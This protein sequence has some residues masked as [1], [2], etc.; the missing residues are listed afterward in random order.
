MANV[1]VF[2][3]KGVALFNEPKYPV[4]Q[5]FEKYVTAINEKHAIEYVFSYFGSKNK[6]KRHNIKI[7]EVKE[8]YVDEIKDKRIKD[9]L[10]LEKLI[11]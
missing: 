1:K 11:L 10:K 4:L 6:I 2:Y 7:I 9:I 3:I 5:K 8:V